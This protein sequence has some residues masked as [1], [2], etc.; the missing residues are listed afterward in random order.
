[1]TFLLGEVLILRGGYRNIFIRRKNI[2]LP[3]PTRKICNGGIKQKERG[4]M[5]AYS[6]VAEQYHFE[7]HQGP[8]YAPYAP[9]LDTPLYIKS[10]IA[11]IAAIL[12]LVKLISP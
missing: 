11:A 12:L 3:P 10:N 5:R 2:L 4:A 8:V 7:S 9:R 1:M 6:T